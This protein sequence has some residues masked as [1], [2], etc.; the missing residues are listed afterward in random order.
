MGS[1]GR[2]GAAV[3]VALLLAAGLAACR[4]AEGPRPAAVGARHVVVVSVAL[5]GGYLDAHL[6]GRPWSVGPVSGSPLDLRFFF[7]ADARCVRLLAPES[8]LEYVSRG[9]FGR[10]RSGDEECEALGVGPLEAWRD[11]RG[12][13]DVAATRDSLVP[14]DVA[15]F[16]VIHRDEEVVLV[17]GRFRLAGLAAIPGG[18]DLVAVLPNTRDC[19]RPIEAGEAS[20]EYRASGRP[21]FALVGPDGLCPVLGFVQPLAP[22]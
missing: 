16:A 12:R 13:P 4:G 11:R 5:R 21:A 3:A 10:V 17:R 1:R 8:E 7:P 2:L 6:Y 20:L 15:R 9:V 18:D 19:R 22:S 14:R